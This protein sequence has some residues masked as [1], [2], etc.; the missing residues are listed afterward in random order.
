LYKEN[1]EQRQDGGALR[2]TLGVEMKSEAPDGQ[3]DT[4]YRIKTTHPALGEY[5]QGKVVMGDAMLVRVTQRPGA[6]VLADC[7]NMETQETLGPAIVANQYGRGR[8]IYVGGSLEANYVSSRIPS[9]RRM[10]ASMVRYLGADAPMPFSM[11]APRGVYGVLRRAPG[12]DLALWI[13]ANVGFK[14][15]TV[16]R[17]RQEFIPVANVEVKIRV[18]E[19]KQVKSVHLV[20]SDQSVP[21]TLSGEYAMMTIP[22]LHIAELVHVALA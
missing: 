15:A 16:G 1:G 2:E 13:C 5:H 4:F 9:L 21:F 6:T 14:D 17:M 18:P 22:N 12:G 3:T 19:G 11:V 10:L 7:V 8:A 20:R